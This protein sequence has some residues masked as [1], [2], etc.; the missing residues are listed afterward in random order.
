M[1][2]KVKKDWNSLLLNKYTSSLQRSRARWW[3]EQVACSLKKR[4]S[5]LSQF[6]LGSPLARFIR[7]IACSL[8]SNE[9]KKI[10][11]N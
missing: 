10:Q 11:T 4:A 8:T 6:A 1:I 2:V 5:F 9:S 7:G 3:G